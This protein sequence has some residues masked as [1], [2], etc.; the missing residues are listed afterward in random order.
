VFVTEEKSKELKAS[1]VEKGDIVITHRG[2]LGQV[3]IISAD[4][5]YDKYIISQSGLKMSF[6]KELINPYYIYYFLNTRLGQHLL[7]MNR[8]QVGVPAI[9]QPTT[10]VKKIMIPFPSLE[11]QGTIV[12]I[13]KSLDDKIELNNQIN[14]T[15]EEMAQCIFKEWF[16]EFNFPNEE[17]VPY[18]DNG[19]E[20]VE[21]ELG[22]IPEGWRVGSIGE[23]ADIVAG[24][25]P[26][27]KVDEYYAEEREI[28]WITPKDL[29]G[30]NRKFIGRGALDITE[31]GLRKSSAKI[32]P[33]GTVLFSSRAPIGYIAIAENDVT[34]NQGFK[35][36]IPNKE[37]GTEYLYYMLHN[38][39]GNIENSASGS[40][41]KEIS[42]AGMKK[43]EIIIPTIPVAF[44]FEKTVSKLSDMILKNEIEIEALTEIRNTLL[45]KL[46]SGEI[47]V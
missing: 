27:K 46:M 35:S 16:V 43:H 40:T 7:L 47:R 14:Q 5:K 24:G 6:N 33:K 22:E 1:W 34:T 42:G 3:G 18:K 26:S 19:G 32:M 37:F 28:P 20:M 41:F 8:S 36:L 30:Y 9:A 39:K 38:I 10:S 21:S 13:L 25:T 12:E 45:P 11:K 44:N 29:S 4:S 17:G 15:L 31:L 2:T 23:I